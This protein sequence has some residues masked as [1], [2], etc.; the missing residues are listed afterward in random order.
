MTCRNGKNICSGDVRR[1]FWFR[2]WLSTYPSGSRVSLCRFDP[3]SL[4]ML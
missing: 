2:Y 3:L 1:V 4:V